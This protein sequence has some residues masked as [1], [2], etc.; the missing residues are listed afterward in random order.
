[1]S[2]AQS[3]QDT[4]R[5]LTLWFKYG[6]MKEIETALLEGFSTVRIDTW[7]QVIPQI[8][9]RIA[10]PMNS[11][12][13]MVQELLVNIGKEH[14]QAVVFP[15]NVALKS[16]APQRIAAAETVM[17]QIKKHSPVLVEQSLMVAQELVRVAI[18]WYEMWFEG[19]E[20]ASRLHFAEH[21]AEEAILRLKPLHDMLEETVHL[22][23]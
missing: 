8:I 15:L 16:E 10:S 14:P 18:L 12:R 13:Q 3:L 19:L 9:A 6:N 4:L 1:L 2:P 11:V 23:G 22:Y 20:D 7:L 21:N 5:I 17:K